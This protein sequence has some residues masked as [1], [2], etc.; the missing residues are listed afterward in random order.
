M[1]PVM[2]QFPNVSLVTSKREMFGSKNKSSDLPLLHFQ[3]GHNVIY[4]S[5]REKAGNWIGEPTTVMFRKSALSIGGFNTSYTCL[6]DWEM[7]LRILTAGDCYI[8]PETLSYFRVHDKQASKLVMNDYKYTFEDY[9]FYKSMQT[10]NPLHLDLSKIE[11]QGMIRKRAVFCAKAM[12]KMLPHIASKKP[13]EIFL[14]AF[15]I[16]REEGVLLA[17]LMQLVR[18]KKS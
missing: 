18:A 14:K 3:E 2:E 4:A 7:W 6:V 16:A 12:Y 5:L 1:V 17:P 8:I 9:R 15:R 13:R 10:E 11:L